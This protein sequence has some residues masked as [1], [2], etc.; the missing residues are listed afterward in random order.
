M[1]LVNAVVV[2][3]HVVGVDIGNHG[4]QGREVEKRSVRLIGF[5][6]N[7]LAGAQFGI[8]AR[9]GESPANHKS[10]IQIRRRQH[11]R[12]EAGGGGFAVGAGNGNAVAKTHDFRQH[13]RARNH[14]NFM[15]LCGGHFGIVFF[16]R[17]GRYHHIGTGNMLGSMALVYRH[18]DVLQMAGGGID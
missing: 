12:G 8:A 2:G 9:G 1:Q 18:A 13:H 7:I 14:R 3:F 4:K 11:R 16:N 17:G 6:H 10:G 15:D 5:G